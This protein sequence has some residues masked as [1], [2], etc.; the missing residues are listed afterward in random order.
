MPGHILFSPDWKSDSGWD[1]NEAIKVAYFNA[2]QIKDKFDVNSDEVDIQ[3]ELNKRN[4]PYF[5]STDFDDAN[6]PQH[7]LNDRYGMLYKVIEY[8]HL[9]Q[10]KKKVEFLYS[11]DGR[12][13]EVPD[14][15]SD[16]E[17][18]EWAMFNELDIETVQEHEI[19]YKKYKKTIVIPNLFIDKPVEDKDAYIQIGRLPF[20]HASVGRVN[21]KDCGKVDDY[22]DVQKTINKRESLIDHIIANSAAGATAIDPEIVGNDYQAMENI[23]TNWNN[24]TFKFFTRSGE[25]ASGRKH[26]EELPRAQYQAH[27]S[28]E[29]NRMYDLSDRI[30]EVPPVIDGR[31]EG[32]ED[33]SGIVIAR[34]AQN[35]E[36]GMTMI[37]KTLE[38]HLNEKGEAYMALAKNLYGQVFREFKVAG[39]NK[40]VSINEQVETEEGNTKVIN[41]ITKL[42]RHKVIISQA[43]QGTTYR[44]VQRS[45]NAE[46]LKYIPAQNP[47]SRS[48]AVGNVMR[49][50]DNS[51]EER[52]K[53]EVAADLEEQLAFESVQTQIAGFKAQRSQLENPQPQPGAE[54][55]QAQGQEQP[56]VSPEQGPQEVPAV[57]PQ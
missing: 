1:C 30:T 16:E 53:Y 9:E 29:L 4:G 34:K 7:D 57:L 47:I 32:S 21:G 36:I 37:F 42:P 49:N 50:L 3:I 11:S 51:T 12:L 15:Y 28:E 20:F 33:R 14:A 6:I 8:H 19:K 18:Q 45:I 24:P 41:D 17:K 35:A 52:K 48:L 55:E 46:L 13:V 40:S 38:R 23:K 27:V 44:E 39:E 25:L 22:K 10:D 43:T 26:F 56:E 54:G 31:S 2:E 5:N